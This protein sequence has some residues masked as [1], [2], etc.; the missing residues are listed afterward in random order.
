MLKFGPGNNVTGYIGEHAL[1]GMVKD[2]A[3]TTQCA[4]HEYESN[5]IKYAMT[6]ISSEIGVPRHPSK[7]AMKG[8]NL[9]EGLQ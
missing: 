5:V 3:E 8:Q 7:K 1:K 2:H 6:D 9:E 4:I